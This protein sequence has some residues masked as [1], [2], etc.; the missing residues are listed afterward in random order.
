MLKKSFE[1]FTRGE[2]VTIGARYLPATK[3]T[4]RYKDGQTASL[5]VANSGIARAIVREAF[6]AQ[7]HGV[8]FN[9]FKKSDSGLNWY[10]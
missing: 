1:N 7:E 8:S 6:D 5:Y 4:K 3:W 9:C 10:R 2:S